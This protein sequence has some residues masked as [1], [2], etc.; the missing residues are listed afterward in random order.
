MS[1]PL[2][3]LIRPDVQSCSTFTSYLIGMSSPLP[4]SADCCRVRARSLFARAVAEDDLGRRERLLVEGEQ[5]MMR[6]R[7]W[8]PEQDG[9]SGL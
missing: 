5:W 3:R 2:N 9:P 1:L 7:L 4:V 6:W 8:Q